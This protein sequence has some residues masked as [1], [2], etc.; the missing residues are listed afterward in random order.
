MKIDMVIDGQWGSTGKGK[1][2]HF[3]LSKGGYE[4][5]LCDFAANAGHT[6]YH[7]G[8]KVVLHHL[9]MGACYPDMPIFLGPGCIINLRVLHEEI[10][11][12]DCAD[13]IAISP[14]ATI[15]QAKHQ[16]A[17]TVSTRHIASTQQGVGEALS[18]KIMRDEFVV[19]ARGVPKLAEYVERWREEFPALVHGR[20]RCLAE[21]AQGIDLSLDGRF[22]PYVTSRN[23]NPAACLDRLGPF[24]PRQLGHVH[25]SLRTFPIRVGNMPPTAELPEASSGPVYPGQEELDW[26][27]FGIE[28]EITTTSKRP[29]RIF[30]WSDEQFEKAV[31][32]TAPYSVFFNFVNYLHED[33]HQVTT[34]EGLPPTVHTWL[35]EKIMILCTLH[36]QMGIPRPIMYLGT[37]SGQA[38]MV[39]LEVL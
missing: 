1:L 9:P 3:L 19:L 14:N 24:H 33:A 28:P 35:R 36:G 21:T 2:A 20:G 5:S 10:N 39:E 32:K 31:Q 6:A 26:E 30:R 11:R 18:E 23:I 17:E 4:A 22:F 7:N 13:R 27:H 37:G 16:F 8:E 12:H 15:I 34:Y 38:H 25:L 29:R